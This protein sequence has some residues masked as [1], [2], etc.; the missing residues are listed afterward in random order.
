MSGKSR[1]S[2]EQ[3]RAIKDEPQAQHCLGEIEAALAR[4]QP[5]FRVL[6]DLSGLASMDIACAEAIRQ[7]MDLCQDKGVAEIVRIIPDPQKDIGLQLMSHFHYARDVPDP[8]LYHLGG[9]IGAVGVTALGR[10]GERRSDRWEMMRACEP[11]RAAQSPDE[12]MR[13][14]PFGPKIVCHS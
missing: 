10:Q 13:R 2:T 9:G 6:T 8:H 4:M 7:I 14:H 3:E 1:S 12:G 5:D 11:G